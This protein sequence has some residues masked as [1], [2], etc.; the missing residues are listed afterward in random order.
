RRG[1]GAAAAE[2]RAA[3]LLLRR[4]ALNGLPRGRPSGGRGRLPER[5]RDGGRREGLE[6]GREDRRQAVK[7]GDG[8]R[9]RISAKPRTFARL[10]LLDGLLS[11]A[12]VLAGA[13]A[14]AQRIGEG[15]L[16]EPPAADPRTLRRHGGP[17]ASRRQLGAGFP[18][19]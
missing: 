7:D 11:P 8:I 14:S 3:R 18:V 2:G 1:G 19:R 10:F 9:R 12:V 13:K 6:G 16:D 5:Q 4:L 17:G 15:D